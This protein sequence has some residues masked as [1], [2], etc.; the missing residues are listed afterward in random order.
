MSRV[1]RHEAPDD[2]HLLTVKF[3]TWRSETFSKIWIKQR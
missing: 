1:H 3:W 2:C